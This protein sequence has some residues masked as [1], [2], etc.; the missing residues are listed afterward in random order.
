MYMY[1]NNTPKPLLPQCMVGTLHIWLHIV[2]NL[3]LR[4]MNM[5][6]HNTFNVEKHRNFVHVVPFSCLLIAMCRDLK[7]ENIMLNSTGHVVLTDFGLS[8]ESLY[9]D[10]TT[11]TFCGTVEYM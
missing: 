5:V 9:G 6:Y 10:A 11:H 2:L 8:K 1:Y 7:P 4:R 3:L